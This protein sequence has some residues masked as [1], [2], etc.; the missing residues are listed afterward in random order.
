MTAV[1]KPSV[2]KLSTAL[3]TARNGFCYLTI[4]QFGR[5]RGA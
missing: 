4:R 5:N 1:P 2:A 3:I